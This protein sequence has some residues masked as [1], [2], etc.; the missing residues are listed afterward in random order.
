MKVTVLSCILCAWYSAEM[1]INIISMCIEWL[2]T[3]VNAATYR[4]VCVWLRS[5]FCKLHDITEAIRILS[6][7]KLL[8]FVIYIMLMWSRF[9]TVHTRGA[10]CMTPRYLQY[11]YLQLCSK[12]NKKLSS[13]L[14]VLS[15]L[16]WRNDAVWRVAVNTTMADEV[17]E[18]IQ[19]VW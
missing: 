13:A 11:S 14:L 12:Q 5:F 18:P 3:C 7:F 6:S 10:F 15:Q 8:M 4:C 16:M 19:G 2:E 9:H 1:F 17:E